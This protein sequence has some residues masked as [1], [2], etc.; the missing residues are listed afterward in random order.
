[1]KNKLSTACKHWIASSY[2]AP[3]NAYGMIK[4]DIAFRFEIRF[5][6]FEAIRFIYIISLLHIFKLYSMHFSIRNLFQ[7]LLMQH[8]PFRYVI[9]QRV[10]DRNL[11]PPKY[12]EKNMC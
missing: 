9:K 4:N 12:S 10:F 3:H 5:S 6:S 2:L 1:M 11:K 8:T 7:M